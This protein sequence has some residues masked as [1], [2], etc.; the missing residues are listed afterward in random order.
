[1]RSGVF[2]GGKKAIL[3]SDYYTLMNMVGSII[4]KLTDKTDT[5]SQ[6]KRVFRV[7]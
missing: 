7:D 2:H 5:F 1:M 3:D 6:S 4:A